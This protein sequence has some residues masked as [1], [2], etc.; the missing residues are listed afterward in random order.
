MKHTY[1]Q[2]SDVDL[3][4]SYQTKNDNQ[5]LETLLERHSNLLKKLANKHQLSHPNTI[6]EDCYQNAIIG[7]GSV[8]INDI[9][10]NTTV[11]GNPGRIIKINRDI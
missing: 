5:A 6:F 1:M 10:N 9:P 2:Q 8:V 11:V 4:V 7:A 3:V